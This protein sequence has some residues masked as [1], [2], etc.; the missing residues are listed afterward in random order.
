MEEEA[1]A[2]PHDF[3]RTPGTRRRESGEPEHEVADVLAKEAET[4]DG[5]C[6]FVDLCVSS[7]VLLLRIHSPLHGQQK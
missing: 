3:V 7:P 2:A 1:N 6:S 5:D 4:Q